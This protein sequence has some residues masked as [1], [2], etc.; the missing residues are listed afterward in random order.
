MTGTLIGSAIGVGIWLI[1]GNVSIHSLKSRFK[2]D[3]TSSEIPLTLLGIS[4]GLFWFDSILLGV[5]IGAG[6]YWLLGEIKNQRQYQNESR[7]FLRESLMM[8]NFVE[9]LAMTLTAGLPL[10]QALSVSLEKAPVELK[11]IWNDVMAGLESK[12]FSQRLHQISANWPLSES[13]RLA[14]QIL[15]ASERGTPMLPMLDAFAS[16]VRSSNQRKLLEKAAQKEVWMMIP[17]VFGILPA[18]TVVAVFPALTTL[19]QL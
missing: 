15:I 2:I 14:D 1:L 18:V 11:T 12:T 6:I 7:F 16:E 10:V 8:P 3:S 9:S 19:S 5:L 4:F 17:V 13:A